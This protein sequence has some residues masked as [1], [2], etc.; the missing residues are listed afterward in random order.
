MRHIRPIRQNMRSLPRT[1]GCPIQD[2]PTVMGGGLHIIHLHPTH[3][4]R[5]PR[6][7]VEHHLAR[8]QFAPRI[9]Q[10]HPETKVVFMSGHSED[11]VRESAAPGENIA[12]IQKP[13]SPVALCQ[14]VRK[15]LDQ[16]TEKTGK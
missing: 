3:R 16:R 2:R 14:L 6:R 12:F 11:L 1:S 7:T 9:R 5:V 4:V 13:F 8:P 15:V 10:L